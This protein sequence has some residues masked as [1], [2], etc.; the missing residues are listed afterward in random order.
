MSTNL[1]FLL[2]PRSVAVIGASRSVS[3]VGGSILRNLLANAFAGPVFPVNSHATE[4]QSVR[5]FRSITDVPEPV[6]LAIVAIPAA[7]VVAAA[8]EC[9]SR[10]VKAMV[11]I[12]AGFA[13]ASAE[14]ARAQ[15]EL[16][17]I[18]RSNGIRLVGPNCFGVVNSDPAVRLAATFGRCELRPGNVSFCSQSGALGLA[19][20]DKARELGIGV[21]QFVSIG[22][23][24][25]VSTNDL[26]EYWGSDAGTQTILL[27]A[28]SFG[29]TDRFLEI[30]SRVSR[31]KAIVAV[32]SGRSAAGAKAAMSHTGA[33]AG[34]DAAMDALL[35]QAGVIR[36]DT[37]EELFQTA[38]LVSTQ[39]LPL[40]RRVAVVT[41]G[42]G[43]AIMAA[44]ACAARGLEL[45]ALRPETTAALREVLP[46]NAAVGNPIDM[47]A[48]ATAR[49]FDAVLPLLAADPNVDA[50]VGL[51]TP[52]GLT[53][54]TDVAVALART[55]AYA[56]KP[57]LTCIMGTDPVRSARDVLRNAGVPT[58][59]FPESSAVALG[60]A[61]RL[62][63]WRA[64][65]AGV[66]ASAARPR[67][68]PPAANKT[69]WLEPQEVAALFAAH[70]IPT[71]LSATVKS[72]AEAAS[73]A[74]RIGFAVALKI[75]SPTMSHKTEVGGVRVGLEDAG[76]VTH[77]FGEI[78]A[79]LERIDRRREVTA[80]QVQAM[81]PKGVELIAGVTVDP[82]VGSL[83]GFGLGGVTA[84][85]W[86]DVAFRVHPILRV[87]A[88]E[89]LDEIRGAPLLRGFRGAPAVDRAALVSVLLG[90]NDMVSLHPEIV[91]LDINPLIAHAGGAVAVDGR[92]RVST[93]P[94]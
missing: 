33:L 28:E 60:S 26:I 47:I 61:V 40:G 42:G 27:Y 78:V 50:I 68:G 36:T 39:P 21:R 58:Y 85:L 5:A 31:E 48:G 93:P 81:A 29:R 34:G 19:L 91:E 37:L 20:L 64:R 74:S 43:P 22:N 6:D 94:A 9:A 72:A 82:V 84:E 24:A 12:T 79:A 57:V 45:S 7:G 17:E 23:R 52:T 88:E 90:L 41:N 44:D 53:E 32:K 14:G 54:P 86:R 71:A 65:R 63:E 56:R 10:G 75:V 77:A 4:V 83:I 70:A 3:T 8:K 30:A 73:E 15:A 49:S 46:E 16:V 51:F 62:S 76:E 92:V 89:M 87:D 1:D 2:R 35:K 25:D 66:A 80:F 69:R 11:V 59:D 67:K 13:E 38:Q 18:A 55:K